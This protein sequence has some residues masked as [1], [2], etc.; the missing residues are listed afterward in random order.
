MRHFPP[1]R[2][3]PLPELPIQY[4]DYRG[5]AARVAPAAS[6]GASSSPT[7]G[8]QL[9]GAPGCWS[10][11]PTGRGRASQSFHGRAWCAFDAAGGADG[12]ARGAGAARRRDAVHDAAGRLP[13]AAASRYSGQDDV[14]VGTPI[15]N[16]T[17]AEIEGLIGF[18][19]NTL[20]LRADLSGD[21]TFREL[22]AR[23]R[24]TAL[25]AYAHQDL[26][27]EKLV[28]ELQPE[29]DLEP[30]AA[31]PGDVRLA[32]RRAAA[33]RMASG[34]QSSRSRRR[35]SGAKFD[36]SLALARAAVALHGALE[37]NTD[38]FDAATIERMLDA[39]S[40]R[41][42][43]RSSPIRTGGCRTLPLLTPAERQQ[44]L[45]EWNAT[46]RTIRGSAAS[47]SCSRSRRRARRRLS[48]VEFDEER[49]HLR[50]S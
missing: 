43:R 34:L 9:A 6:A 13:G 11:R 8:A 47:T 3:S 36:L 39:S 33:A 26:P 38:L 42:W 2:P 1:G 16:R 7:G 19:V 12:G 48:R 45:V 30:H 4:A 25:G 41:C 35:R 17:R 23:V 31:V 14:V 49:A 18:F 46:R 15:A 32:E 50:A 5:L 44:L 20:A 29:R 40:R 37:Y 10:C 22:L 27:F 24:E 21:P 28:E